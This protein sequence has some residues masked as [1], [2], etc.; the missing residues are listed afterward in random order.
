MGPVKLSGEL[1]PPPPQNPS[2]PASNPPNKGTIRPMVPAYPAVMVLPSKTLAPSKDSSSPSPAS[3]QTNTIAINSPPSTDRSTQELIIKG[4]PRPNPPRSGSLLPM[5]V[6]GLILIATTVTGLA[7]FFFRRRAAFAAHPLIEKQKSPPGLDWKEP[8]PLE[9]AAHEADAQ[10]T[11]DESE[12]SE[13]T[14]NRIS[15]GADKS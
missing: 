2:S 4:S 12:P 9:P 10:K 14:P 6:I 5:I 11:L 3:T 13:L 7:W 8:A 1:K 15:G